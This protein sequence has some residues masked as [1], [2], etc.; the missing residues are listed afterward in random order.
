[1]TTTPR[2]TADALTLTIDGAPHPSFTT[3]TPRGTKHPVSVG[4]GNVFGIEEVDGLKWMA[5]CDDHGTF[6]QTRTKD[7]A[8]TSTGL[9][10]CQDCRDEL[11]EV[12]A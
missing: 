2:E 4:R 12:D 3:R 8:M 11:A 9:D 7:A 5:S 6:V 10:F 1:M